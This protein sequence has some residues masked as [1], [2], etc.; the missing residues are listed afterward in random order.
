MGDN[1]GDGVMG[2]AGR[3]RHLTTLLCFVLLVLLSLSVSLVE[4]NVSY[5]NSV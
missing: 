5:I 2:H 3:A 1:V 4:Y